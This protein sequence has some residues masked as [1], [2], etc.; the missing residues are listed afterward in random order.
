MKEILNPGIECGLKNLDVQ[1]K[2]VE[3]V[4]LKMNSPELDVSRSRFD[5]KLILIRIIRTF[6][7]GPLALDFY[8]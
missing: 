7:L 1:H 8:F 4:K 5:T 2:L 3:C 6:L